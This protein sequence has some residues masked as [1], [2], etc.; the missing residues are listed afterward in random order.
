MNAPRRTCHNPPSLR[1][2]ALRRITVRPCT[3]AALAM[4]VL[5]AGAVSTGAAFAQTAAPPIAGPS[6]EQ[7]A[8]IPAPGVLNYLAQR[9]QTHRL[10]TSYLG[11]NVFG[12]DG[13]RIG[14][15]NDFVVD[16]QPGGVAAIVIGVGGFL[17]LGEKDVAVPL[18]AVRTERIDGAN[19]L[20]MSVTREDLRRAPTFMRGDPRE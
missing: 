20:V 9:T 8:T 13:Q 14:D 2:E 6:S 18:G 7:Q 16:T 19:R 11:K 4:T 3:A 15:V 5:A 17:G 10:A 12:T 1:F